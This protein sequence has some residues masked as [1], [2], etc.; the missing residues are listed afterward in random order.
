MEIPVD[1]LRYRQDR[2][3]TL[4]PPRLAPEMKLVVLVIIQESA[5]IE[6]I[7]FGDEFRRREARI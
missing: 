4:I 2:Y 3:V 6:E 5:I 7:L 1:A